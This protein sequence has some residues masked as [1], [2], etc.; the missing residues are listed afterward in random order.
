MQVLRVFCGG[1]PPLWFLLYPSHTGLV[2]YLSM[3]SVKRNEYYCKYYCKTKHY[4]QQ[5]FSLTYLHS[6]GNPRACPC[7]ERVPQQPDL[8]PHEVM[9]LCSKSYL[10]VQAEGD[11]DMLL[12]GASAKWTECKRQSPTT[13]IIT[14]SK[15]LHN[16]PPAVISVK[17]KVPLELKWMHEAFPAP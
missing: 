13:V 1:M 15:H 10:E 14:T 8:H 6:P 3:Y 11:P 5:W 12:Q 2:P 9:L 16:A 17:W 4:C 7:S